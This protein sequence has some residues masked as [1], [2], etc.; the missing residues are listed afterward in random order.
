MEKIFYPTLVFVSM[1]AWSFLHSWLAAFSTK[2]LARRIFGEGIR[3][4]YR[5]IFVAIAILTLLPISAMLVR[6]PSRRLWVIPS[7]WVYFTVI[8]QFVAIFGLILIVLKTGPMIFIGLRQISNP[9]VERGRE[10]VTTGFYG[11]VRHPLYLLNII[12]IWLFPYMT[13]LILAFVIVSTLYMIIGTIPEEQKLLEIHGEAYQRYQ[14]QV[15]RIIP[16]LKL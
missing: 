15:P 7:P 14:E 6:L 10:M 13:D 2:K 11:L 3:R 12:L 9:N 16:G 5:L 1:A 4:Y 8:I